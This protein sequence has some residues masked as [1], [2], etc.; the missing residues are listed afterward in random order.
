[1]IFVK[2]DREKPAQTLDK[3]TVPVRM[4]PSIES[5]HQ[6]KTMIKTIA[7]TFFVLTAPAVAMPPAAAFQAAHIITTS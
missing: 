2:K 4:Y 5:T 3:V 1:M 6:R 7:L